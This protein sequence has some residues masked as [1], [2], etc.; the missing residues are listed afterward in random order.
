MRCQFN[1]LTFGNSER[2]FQQ[3]E[4]KIVE[5]FNDDMKL[6]KRIEYDKFGRDVDVKSYDGLDNIVDHMQKEYFE[7]ENEKGYVEIFKNKFQEYVRKSYTKIE[8]GMKH[9]I[10]DFTA[11]TNPEKSYFNDF[12]YDLNGKLQKVVSFKK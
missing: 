7:T 8:N 3:G 4:Y 11:K 9:V 5:T 6:I 2:T 1:I 12:I 10:D